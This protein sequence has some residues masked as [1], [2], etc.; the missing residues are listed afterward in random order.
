[1]HTCKKIYP[2]CIRT[3]L[4]EWHSLNFYSV[5]HTK[6]YW[7]YANDLIRVC[8][9]AIY[10]TTLKPNIKRKSNFQIRPRSKAIGSLYKPLCQHF[11]QSPD[12]FLDEL[13]SYLPAILLSHILDYIVYESSDDETHH[14]G[15]NI[16]VFYSDDSTYYLSTICR[17]LLR[18]F[19]SSSN[20]QPH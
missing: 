20:R 16:S 13:F 14:S 6:V 11:L 19:D 8:V 2:N 3:V 10:T 1:M 4:P 15:S 5:L 9:T 17:R 18:Q 12:P 7:N